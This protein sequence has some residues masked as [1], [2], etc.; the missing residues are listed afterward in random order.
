VEG[1]HERRVGYPSKEQD[2][3]TCSPSRRKVVGHLFPKAMNQEQ[4]NTNV[5]G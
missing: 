3:G 1:C 2:M 5:N 4:G